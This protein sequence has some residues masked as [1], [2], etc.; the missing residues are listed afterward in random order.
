MKPIL[1]I[2]MFTILVTFNSCKETDEYQFKAEVIGRNTDCGFFAVKFTENLDQVHEIAD[3]Y[4]LEDIYI[5]KNLPLELQTE[6]SLIVLNIR[7][8]KD[9]ELSICTDR[10]PSYPWIYVL[11]AKTEQ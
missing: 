10:G 8:I 3:T 7:K 11:N 6:G 1:G 5:A 2:L 4:I 9:S